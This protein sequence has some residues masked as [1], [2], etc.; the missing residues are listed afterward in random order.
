MQWKTCIAD[1]FSQRSA[2]ALQLQ[3]MSKNQKLFETHT[4]QIFCISEEKKQIKRIV[5]FWIP[6]L[7]SFEEISTPVQKCM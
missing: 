5:Y 2:I 3:S 1:R 4:C 7:K 6:K